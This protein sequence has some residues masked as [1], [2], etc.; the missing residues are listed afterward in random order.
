MTDVTA[1]RKR[2]LELSTSMYERSVPYIESA[3]PESGVAVPS[4]DRAA[5]D[6]AEGLI[7]GNVFLFTLAA[8]L[9][10][11]DEGDP[12]LGARLARMASEALNSGLDWLEG[13][14]DDLPG[15]PEPQVP[16]QQEIPAV[17]R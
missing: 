16:G 14:N 5:R 4:H 9:R 8:V 2:L 7:A 13:A 11:A 1:V 10:V 3:L 17:A 15:A 6:A 12:L